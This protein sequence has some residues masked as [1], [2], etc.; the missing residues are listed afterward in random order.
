MEKQ[1]TVRDL[2]RAGERGS[3]AGQI[4]VVKDIIAQAKNNALA[5]FEDGNDSAA[6]A[7]RDFAGSLDSLLRIL[8]NKQEGLKSQV[9]REQIADTVID[10]TLEYAELT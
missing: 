2:E 8:A 5:N 3:V 4:A 9:R 7:L 10:A 1:F 6:A